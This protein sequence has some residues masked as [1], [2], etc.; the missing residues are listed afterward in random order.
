MPG[1]DY[2][3][4]KHIIYSTLALLVHF[5]AHLWQRFFPNQ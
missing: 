1:H 4:N 3:S 5:N 2:M